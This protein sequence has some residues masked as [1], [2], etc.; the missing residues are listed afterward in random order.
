MLRLWQYCNVFLY[1]LK[2]IH[3]RKSALFRVRVCFNLLLN[4]R[5]DLLQPHT[6]EVPPNS[7]FVWLN[8]LGMVHKPCKV[9]DGGGTCE[10]GGIPFSQASFQVFHLMDS[11]CLCRYCLLIGSPPYPFSSYASIPTCHFWVAMT[12]QN[13]AELFFFVLFITFTQGQMLLLRFFLTNQVGGFNARFF[14][15]ASV[16][17]LCRQVTTSVPSE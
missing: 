5:G 4:T 16:L 12:T 10:G 17:L 9:C 2:P 13:A 11:L 3:L 6:K 1:F 15:C 8:V 14:Y 7:R